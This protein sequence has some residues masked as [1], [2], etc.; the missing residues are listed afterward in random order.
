MSKY[1]FSKKE[2]IRFYKFYC[3]S[4]WNTHTLVMV[5][6]YPAGVFFQ[7]CLGPYD[8][9]RTPIRRSYCRTHR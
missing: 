1:L 4:A 3:I 5:R 8:A 7:P 6:D 9:S 2:Y